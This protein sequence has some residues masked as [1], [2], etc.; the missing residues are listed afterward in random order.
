MTNRE[1][2][3]K[4][5]LAGEL[6]VM[7][8]L[9]LRGHNPAKSFLEEGADVILEN[10]LRIEIKCGHRC[11]SQTGMRESNNYLFSFRGGSKKQ[12]LTLKDSDFAILWLIDDGC[13]LIIPTDKITGNCVAIAKLSPRFKYIS[14]KENWTLLDSGVKR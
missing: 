8:E 13:F 5:G 3:N 12:R 2:G 7:S 6:R 9:L 4:L 10:G 1:L 14:Y 11:H